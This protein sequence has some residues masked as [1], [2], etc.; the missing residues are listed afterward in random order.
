MF[1]NKV[2]KS[3]LLYFLSEIPSVDLPDFKAKLFVHILGTFNINTGWEK[4]CMFIIFTCMFITFTCMFIAFT[5][6]TSRA[7]ICGACLKLAT[8]PERIVNRL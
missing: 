4:T 7:G 1:R 5:G 8:L 2:P 3:K 6:S